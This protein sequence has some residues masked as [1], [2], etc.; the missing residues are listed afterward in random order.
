[1]V[2]VRMLDDVGGYDLA[3]LDDKL[4]AYTLG[5]HTTNDHMTSFYVHSPSGSFIE[6]GW[7]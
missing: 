1:M 3:Q 2:Q 7:G 6:Y 4:I 5:R